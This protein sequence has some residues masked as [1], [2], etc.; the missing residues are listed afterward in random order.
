MVPQNA[1][2]D[3]SILAELGLIG[4]AACE[5]GQ[6]LFVAMTRRVRDVIN[7]YRPELH[8]MRGPGPRWREKHGIAARNRQIATFRSD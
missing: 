8:Y 2:T 6:R 4:A 3:T 5:M 7:P 1:A